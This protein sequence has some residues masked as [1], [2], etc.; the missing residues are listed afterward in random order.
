MS[1]LLKALD[2]ENARLAAGS[3]DSNK[4]DYS[5]QYHDNQESKQSQKPVSR[6]RTFINFVN[7]KQRAVDQKVSD[8]TRKRGKD[9]LKLIEFDH[10]SFDIF[11]LPPVKE[12]ELYIRSFGRTD[13]R[14]AYIQTNE[15]N[16]DRDIQTEEIELLDKWTQYPA[17]D[18]LGCG[19]DNVES[20]K[21]EMKTP[22]SELESTRMVSFLSKAAQAIGILLNEE[23][24][25]SNEDG[26]KGIKSNLS[27]S[28]GYHQLGMPLILKDRYVTYAN[29]SPSQPNYLLTCYSMPSLNSENT[30]M[31]KGIICVWNIMEPSSPQK[32]LACE[33]QPNCC[34]FSPNRT[35]LVC[36]GMTDGSLVIWDLREQG[37]MHRMIKLDQEEYLFRFPTYNT[38]GVSESENHHSPVQS[39]VPVFPDPTSSQY[40]EETDN[41]GL[42]FQL[43]SVEKNGCVN[44]WVVTEIPSPDSAGSEV[45]LGLSPGGKIKL[46]KSSTI[47]LNSPLK[48]DKGD[49]LQAFEF[50]LSTCDLNHFYVGTDTGYVIH[51]V[52]FGSSAFP[53]GHTSVI[54]TPLKV[55]SID[56]SPFGYSYLLAG[57][58]DGSIHLYHTKLENPLVSWNDLSDGQPCCIQSVRW[59]RSRAAVFFVLDDH[60]NLYTFDLLEGDSRPVHVDK[61]TTGKAVYMT[62]NNDSR[63]L[64]SGLTKCPQLLLALDNG[65]TELHNIKQN[66]IEDKTLE[67]EFLKKFNERF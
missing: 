22:A 30:S 28:D 18:L 45:D 32:Y 9:L 40:K 55:N 13:T 21:Q 10:A 29:Y 34:C 17:E 51:G 26:E 36:A 64:G 59:S 25:T 38:A 16:L 60:S 46:V 58:S 37:Y 63:I 33:S 62:L 57:C 39:L 3:V 27:A 1:D 19:G 65:S 11:D 35:S 52:R 67:G 49:S 4:S 24:T 47:K 42:S 54:D 50:K 6:G 7:A 14:Q 41:S 15:D 61:I 5:D 48:L 44:L 12:Y 56:F 31:Q 2:E 20:V 66:L 53:R 43:A 23:S 8:K